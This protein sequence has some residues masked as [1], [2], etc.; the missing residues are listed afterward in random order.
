MDN[1]ADRPKQP[2][3]DD[4]GRPRCAP[5]L[6]P[7]GIAEHR[8]DQAILD[9]AGFGGDQS[10]PERVLAELSKLTGVELTATDDDLRRA[11][12]SGYLRV[13]SDKEFNVL[14]A[15]RSV[16]AGRTAPVLFP[17]TVFRI[18]A[19]TADPMRFGSGVG[20]DPMRFGSAYGDPMRFGN[21][22]HRPTG[23]PDQPIVDTSAEG[24]GAGNGRDPR[25]RGTG[26]W[27][28]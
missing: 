26:R 15:L 14:D 7:Y 6:S 12:R 27:R 21:V 3:I 17:N 4:D 24:S 25:H 8:P 23:H 20:A 5:H 13:R 11:T 2:F 28:P 10:A 1:S 9:V 19:L 18:G 22:E 16:N